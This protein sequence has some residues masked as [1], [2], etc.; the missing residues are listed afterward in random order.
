MSVRAATIF[1]DGITAFI[2]AVIPLYFIELRQRFKNYK[3]LNRGRYVLLAV[4]LGCVW[5]TVFYGSFIE[6]KML[7]VKKHDVTLG[8]SNDR[9]KIA[10]VTD[11]H[12]GVFKHRE[13]LEKVVDRVNALE[14]D[15]V[16]LGGDIVV[17]TAGLEALEPLHRLKSRLGNY[18]VLGNFDYRVGAVDVRKR[19]ESYGVEVLTNESVPVDVGGRLVRL[20]GMD[21]Y[22]LGDPDWVKAMAGIPAGAVKILAAHNPDM[23]PQA[24]AD[25]VKL[26]IAGHTHGG[27]IRL[28]FIG[29]LTKLPVVIGQRFDKGLFDFGPMR[30]FISPGVGESGARARLFC[31]PEIS[32]LTVEF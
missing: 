21:D 6:P 17:N 11:T 2:L 13:W 22:W 7:T 12:L 15:L 9:L 10:V 14:P 31:P 16:I 23:A 5:L 30:L 28:P 20:I 29:P 24:E 18:A 27:Q 1:F 32:L 3:I 19:I 26:M 4:L 8:A 25:G